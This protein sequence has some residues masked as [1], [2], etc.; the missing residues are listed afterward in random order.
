MIYQ[1]VRTYL[2]LCNL[3][4]FAL[5]FHILLFKT[6]HQLSRHLVC[7]LE[8]LDETVAFKLVKRALFA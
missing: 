5:Q 3:P 4:H 8:S 2:S 6:H 7:K 1:S